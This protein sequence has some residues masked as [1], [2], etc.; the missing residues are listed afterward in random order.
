[1]ERPNI[2]VLLSPD[3]LLWTEHGLLAPNELNPGDNLICLDSKS[4]LSK[5]PL[6]EKPFYY[7]P[8]KLVSINTVHNN[9]VLGG[10][11]KIFTPGGN[12]KAKD[13]EKGTALEMLSEKK[14]NKVF[15]ATDEETL[16]LN[17]K[18]KY[19]DLIIKNETHLAPSIDNRSI[20]KVAVLQSDAVKFK[21]GADVLT[22]SILMSQL[23]HR[24]ITYCQN[25]YL[26]HYSKSIV[27]QRMRSSALNTISLIT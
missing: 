6:P 23:K 14:C 12:I 4:N 21:L 26:L 22:D 3:C 9:T 2:G 27:D 16:Y 5:F 17:I 15:L 11:T 1:M 18:N 10:N 25:F 24:L 19:G 7:G 13:I 20:H 8:T